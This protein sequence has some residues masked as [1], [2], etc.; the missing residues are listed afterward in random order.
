MIYNLQ[1]EQYTPCSI[2]TDVVLGLKAYTSKATKNQLHWHHKTALLVVMIIAI[3]AAA[4]AVTATCNLLFVLFSCRSFSCLFLL[5]V[6]SRNHLNQ[7]SH[8]SKED[9]CNAQAL[10]SVIL[11]N[12]LKRL[13]QRLGA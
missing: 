1:L 10:F 12:N 3:T 9:A 13:L 8:L 5:V 4:T 6:T 2:L 11:C 7:F